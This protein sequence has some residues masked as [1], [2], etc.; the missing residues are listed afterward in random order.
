MVR[1]ANTVNGPQRRIQLPGSG[2]DD[3]FGVAEPRLP[4]ARAEMP[5]TSRPGDIHAAFQRGEEALAH[6][7]VVGVSDRIEGR[8]PASQQLLT[9]TPD[10]LR[11]PTR[12][13]P[14]RQRSACC[15]RAGIGHAAALPSPATNSLCRILDQ[16]DV[17]FE[18]SLPRPEWGEPEPRTAACRVPQGGSRAMVM[19]SESLLC[20]ALP[21]GWAMDKRPR[22]TA[23]TDPADLLVAG[24]GDRGDGRGDDCSRPDR[25]GRR[26]S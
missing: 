14:M 25:A 17:S 8:T 23:A 2:P 9:S 12:A 1:G 22:S 18:R 13:R 10:R 26:T 21:L 3:A 11:R 16:M 7:V 5:L 19:A 20:L 15:A 4:I 24:L 6:C